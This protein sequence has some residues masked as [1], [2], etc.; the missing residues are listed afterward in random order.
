MLTLSFCVLV[1][2]APP[3]TTTTNLPTTEEQWHQLPL[4]LAM[5]PK[6][7]LTQSETKDGEESEAQHQS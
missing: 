5:I 2:R 7:I 4:S 6:H 3:T 1:C